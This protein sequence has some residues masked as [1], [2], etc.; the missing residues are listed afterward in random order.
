ME[1]LH[2]MC[3]LC[4]ENAIA[5]NAGTNGSVH[6]VLIHHIQEDF[7][8]LGKT[9]SSL[10]RDDRSQTT[11]ELADM[12]NC[13]PAKNNCLTL[14]KCII[15]ISSCLICFLSFSVRAKTLNKIPRRTI[16]VLLFSF[17]Y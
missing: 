13:D 5:E 2:N 11:R 10:I 3:S 17:L 14:V 12:I 16:S 8:S 6:I 7:R 4:G 15:I 1:G 9:F